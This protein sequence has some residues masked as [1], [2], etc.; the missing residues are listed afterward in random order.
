MNTGQLNNE[1]AI[2]RHLL[3]VGRFT[4]PAVSPLAIDR[5]SP[6]TDRQ[7]GPPRHRLLKPMVKNFEPDI[8]RHRHPIEAVPTDAYDLD[9]ELHDY[10]TDTK[11][12][13]QPAMYTDYIRRWTVAIRFFSQA[14]DVSHCLAE[15]FQKQAEEKQIRRISLTAVPTNEHLTK[16][17]ARR[18]PRFYRGWQPSDT[19]ACATSLDT[20][21]TVAFVAA[22]AH[23]DEF[24]PLN[25]SF[26]S[27]ISFYFDDDFIDESGLFQS[28]KN[29]HPCVDPSPRT[30]VLNSSTSLVAS[31][32]RSNHSPN[33][34][35]MTSSSKNSSTAGRISPRTEHISPNYDESA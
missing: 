26:I 32:P 13:D 11:E 24:R 2:A 33:A 10:Q 5:S 19:R 21:R 35:V 12:M 4:G 14:R 1:D 8:P 15:F 16:R 3:D 25:K 28:R 20:R 30:R 6:N 22:C 17:L 31:S 23:T 9:K 34:S 29:L 18:V 7:M 27:T